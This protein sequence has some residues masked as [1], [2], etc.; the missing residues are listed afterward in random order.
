MTQDKLLQLKPGKKRENNYINI[1]ADWRGKRILSVNLK[2]NHV[3]RLFQPSI[4]HVVHW[5]S[6]N[7]R[8]VVLKEMVAWIQKCHQ[9]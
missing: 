7:D 8:M 9:L 6:E 3:S 1:W 2:G 5:A 4:L